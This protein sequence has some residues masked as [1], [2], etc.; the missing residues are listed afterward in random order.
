MVLI[1]NAAYSFSLQPQNGIPIIN[2]YD[3]KQDQVS[4]CTSQGIALPAEL[5]DGTE[6]NEGCAPI[7]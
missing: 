2:F 5:P 7:Q 3:N 4:R 6:D 1:D